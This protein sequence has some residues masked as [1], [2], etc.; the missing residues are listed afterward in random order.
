MGNQN[1][2]AAYFTRGTGHNEYGNYSE[3]PENWSKM[4]TRI[5]KKLENAIPQLPGPVFRGSK[6]HD[7]EIGIIGMGSTDDALRETQ[8]KLAEMG[9]H[10]DYMRVRSLP[11]DPA[12]REFIASHT[13]NYVLELNRDGQ[14]WQILSLE[15]S[16]YSQKMISITDIGGMPMTAVWAVEN[17]VNQERKKGKRG[18]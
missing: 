9:I 4:L 1:P 8:D 18:N 16:E 10:V 12:V 2:R 7:V 3:D 17:I 14:L 15:I 11:T 13:R 5:G 6:K